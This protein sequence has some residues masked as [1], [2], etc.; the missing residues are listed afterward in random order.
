M[1][2]TVVESG[3]RVKHS[4]HA[5]MISSGRLCDL[6]S[7]GYTVAEAS[8]ESDAILASVVPFLCTGCG[9]TASGS[10]TVEALV[11]SGL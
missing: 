1:Q 8:F 9:G 10:V 7:Y 4:P 11:L 3:L 2:G 6:T 5:T